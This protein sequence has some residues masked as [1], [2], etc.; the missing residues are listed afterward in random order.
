[1]PLRLRFFDAPASVECRSQALEA[2]LGL[3]YRDARVPEVPAAASRYRLGPGAEWLPPGEEDAVQLAGPP[4]SDR[5]AHA[6]FFSSLAAQVGSHWLLHAAGLSAPGGGLLLVGGSGCGKST[7]ALALAQRGYGWFSDEAAAIER[8]SG[9]LVPFPRGALLRPGTVAL[10]PQMAGQASPW[11]LE[12]E[13]D[14]AACWHPPRQ[15]ELAPVRWIF[16][17][18]CQPEEAPARVALSHLPEGL[19]RRLRGDDELARGAPAPAAGCVLME[20]PRPLPARALRRL[21]T[22]CEEEGAALLNWDSP[23]APHTFAG[24][25]RVRQVEASEVWL[26]A[27]GAAWNRP[28][29]GGPPLRRFL[30]ELAGALGSARWFELRPGPLWETVAAIQ[31]VCGEAEAAT[32]CFGRA[33]CLPSGRGRPA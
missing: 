13:D 15:A 21:A 18:G 12:G 33:A 24:R 16:L 14:A 2:A 7:L 22:L 30:Q 23:G 5:L 10:L 29:G 6:L 8:A 3:L 25:A 27:A 31:E 20:W 9:H 1:M 19:A 11:P 26:H 32:R 17:L 28:S 4:V